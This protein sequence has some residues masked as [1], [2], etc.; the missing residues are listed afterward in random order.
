MNVDTAVN[1]S[2]GSTSIFVRPVRCILVER[3][4]RECMLF[5]DVEDLREE[6]LD[7]ILKKAL[8]AEALIYKAGVRR[9]D[10]CPS[11]IVIGGSHYT[12]DGIPLH[13]MEI[14]VKVFDFYIAVVVSY[15]H[16]AGRKYTGPSGIRDF[17]SPSKL[18]NPVVTRFSN[19]MDFSMHGWCSDAD[20]E[21]EQWLSKHLHDVDRYPPVI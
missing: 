17:S 18:P 10:V 2:D 11:N 8:V 16:C 4:Y 6:A 1:P 20:R 9:Q 21:A 19:I 5:L 13:D 14:E 7:L 12:E 15:P 3:L